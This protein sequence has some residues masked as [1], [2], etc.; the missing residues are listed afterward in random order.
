[1]RPVCF[2]FSVILAVT[3]FIPNPPQP[4]TIAGRIEIKVTPPEPVA[5]RYPSQGSQIQRNIVPIPTVVFLD[6]PIQGTSAWPEIPAASIMQKDFQF[7]PSLLVIPV[8]TSVSFPNMDSEFHNVFSYSKSKRFDLGRY[9]K[10]ES[11]SVRFDKP[12]IVKIYC[13]V[14]AWMRAAVLVL[15][16]PHFA[17]VSRDGS[18]SMRGIPAG[19]YDLVVWNID[20]G[21]KKIGVDVAAGKTPEVTVR[22]TGKYEVEGLEPVSPGPAD[23]NNVFP[24]EACCVGKR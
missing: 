21:S 11:K 13:E 5:S 1:M 12:G 3:Q 22:L 23:R 24:K 19:H 2:L 6:G 7:S 4:G 14:H 15:E 9:P 8:N 16:N 17:I 20:A 18:F 10:G